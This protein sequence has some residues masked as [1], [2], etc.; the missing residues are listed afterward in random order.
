MLIS[1]FI[2]GDMSIGTDNNIDRTRASAH[3]EQPLGQSA[4]QEIQEGEHAGRVFSSPPSEKAGKNDEE[5][6]GL[7]KNMNPS[8]WTD[9]KESIGA[10][11]SWLGEGLKA[12]A[13]TV[14][15]AVKFCLFCRFDYEEQEDVDPVSSSKIQQLPDTTPTIGQGTEETQNEVRIIE[16]RDS[17]QDSVQQLLR[18]QGIDTDWTVVE[19]NIGEDGAITLEL[20]VP[21]QWAKDIERSNIYLN[22][23]LK[24]PADQRNRMSFRFDF[25]RDLINQLDNQMIFRN[26]AYLLTQAAVATFI[27]EAETIG[28]GG[29]RSE[30]N[31]EYSINELKNENGQVEFYQLIV[32]AHLTVYKKDADG[33][34]DD[35]LIVNNYVSVKREILISKKDMEENWEDPSSRISLIG[36]KNQ[37]GL[38]SEELAQLAK[39]ETGG[40]SLQVVDT[41]F[42][43]KDKAV[44]KEQAQQHPSSLLKP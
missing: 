10:K 7:T 17:A 35:E 37:E 26:V 5:I 15:E 28:E 18:G 6:G 21:K 30:D 43:G 24:T 39:D 38:S 1:T 29:S 3:L 34:V 33:M 36:K 13:Q 8:Q 41:Y 42:V 22:D 27:E 2:R 25:H 32:L 23:E 44:V 12:L 31:C 16:E 9:I 40:G 4:K 14:W 11:I 20:S 19:N